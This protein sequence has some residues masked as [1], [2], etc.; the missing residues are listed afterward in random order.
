MPNRFALALL[1][2]P[3]FAFAEPPVG[4]PRP[5]KAADATTQAAPASQPTK[6]A[7]QPIAEKLSITDH[8]LKLAGGEILKY[9][10]TA[11]TLPLKDD[12][13]KLRANFFFTAYEKHLDAGASVDQRPIMFVFNGGPGAASIWLH[14][15]TAGPQRI[16]LNGE[17]YPAA[18]PYKLVDNTSTWLIS[19]DLVFIDPVGTGF[20]RP[21]EGVKGE[22]FFGVQQDIDS[23]GEFIRNYLTRSNRWGSPKYIAGESYG[24]TRCA[25]LAEHLHDRY[26][27]ALNGVILIST[28]LNFQTL[29]ANAGNDLP[30]PLFFPTY[31][32]AAHYHKML[33]PDLQA[34]FDKTRKEVEGWATNTYTPALLRGSSL[35]ADERQAIVKAIA[36]YTS[37]SESFIEK[38]N[39]RIDP[40]EFEKE[41]L[42]A[43]R[44]VIG[45]F[46]GRITGDAIEP[47]APSA[48][49]DPSLSLYVGVYNSNFNRYVRQELKFESDLTYEFLSPRVHPWNWGGRG[50]NSGWL[51]VADN[52]KR[53]MTK[54]PHLRLLV[55]SGYYDLAT[56][57]FATNY[58]LN[59]MALP[60]KIQKNVTQTFYSGGH[61][62]YHHK[63][64]MEKLNGD[65]RAFI[66]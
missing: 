25:M 2:I 23:V 62:M 21:A 11:G 39:L 7:A 15:G 66:K 37:L 4:T 65:V 46:D 20:S 18:P 56:P 60:E 16:E 10:A 13:G 61:M 52:L 34:D 44:Q 22:E 49:Y 19:A 36:R 3:A 47:G 30:Y 24:T 43:K 58:T 12:A 33:T 29:S 26:G 38:N 14:I 27:M 57:Y 32:A 53:A 42:S 55:A 1:L 8:E 17:G 45:R 40:S 5:T 6:P 51:Y 63:E 48:E 31:T 54:N 35:P 28:V 50:G 59:H 41:L 64:S 9:K